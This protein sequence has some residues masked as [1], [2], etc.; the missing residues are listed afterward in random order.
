MGAGAGMMMISQQDGSA[1]KVLA[2][3]P[4]ILSSISGAHMVERRERTNSCL[5]THAVTYM[6]YVQSTSANRYTC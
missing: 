6:H 4:N 1:G 5:H 2:D 3:K